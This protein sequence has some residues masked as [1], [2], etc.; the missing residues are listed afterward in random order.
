MPVDPYILLDS[1]SL[2]KAHAIPMGLAGEPTFEEIPTDEEIGKKSDGTPIFKM[3]RVPIEYFRK[4]LVRAGHWVHRGARSELT[5]EPIEFDITHNDIDE[6]VANFKNRKTAGI[7]PQITNFHSFKSVPDNTNGPIIDVSREGDSMFGTLKLIGEKSI[8]KATK[9]DVSVGLVNGDDPCVNVDAYGKRYKGRVLH[10]VSFTDN[11]NQPHLE[12]FVR[13]AA[14]ADRPAMQIPVFTL[15]TAQH[16]APS[17]RSYKMKPE[18]AKQVR[19]KL[20]FGADVPDDQLDSKA[21][22]KALALSGDVQTLSVTLATESK[23]ADDAEKLVKVKG[24]E[25]LALAG[26]RPDFSKLGPADRNAFTKNCARSRESLVKSGLIH[27]SELQ[28]IETRFLKNA[29]GGYSQIALAAVGP[30][31]NYLAYEF[32]DMLNEALSSKGGIRSGNAIDRD[33]DSKARELALSGGGDE[34][35]D[36]ADMIAEEKRAAEEW[37]KQELS[38]RGVTA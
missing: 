21:A 32:Y 11:P 25:M 5:G 31:S 3:R 38:K 36:Q 33:A 18:L 17:R 14:S 30:D 8:E 29:N 26:D 4:E 24:D 20:G 27:D 34:G 23:R 9:Y 37:R 13:I 6:A 7:H 22:E 15:A 10:H 16:A 2:S 19:E 35:A 28:K 1:S 12:P